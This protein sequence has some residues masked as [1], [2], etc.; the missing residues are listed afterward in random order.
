MKQN[1]ILFLLGSVCIVVFAWI[2]FGLVHS[3]LTSTINS[4][5]IQSIQPIQPTFDQKTIDAMGKK[6]PV[7]PAIIIQPQKNQDIVVTTAPTQPPV[8][9]EPTPIATTGGTLR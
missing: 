4:G 2:A 1:E 6:T 9:I 7:L 8:T 3:S 5:T